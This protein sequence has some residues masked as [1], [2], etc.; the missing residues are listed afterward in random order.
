MHCST[1]GGNGVSPVV[2]HPTE[3]TERHTLARGAEEAVAGLSQARAFGGRPVNWLTDWGHP[4][5]AKFALVD[6]EVD[7]SDHYR[8]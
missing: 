8:T 2:S 4:T 5:R 6:G 3:P 7:G 1:A